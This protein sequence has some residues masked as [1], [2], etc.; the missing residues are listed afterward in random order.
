MCEGRWNGERCGCYCEEGSE[1]VSVEKK[2]VAALLSQKVETLC[3]FFFNLHSGV[4][5][6]SQTFLV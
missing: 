4:K 1:M 3:Q 6:S 5:Q 2:P